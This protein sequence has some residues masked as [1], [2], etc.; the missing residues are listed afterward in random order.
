MLFKFGL[1]KKILRGHR[2]EHDAAV[3]D[4]VRTW[5]DNQPLRHINKPLHT[6]WDRYVLKWKDFMQRDD[7]V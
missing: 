6:H 7:I 4:A 1:P 3:E 5:L 2:F